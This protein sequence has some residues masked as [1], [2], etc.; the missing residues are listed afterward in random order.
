MPET[1][2]PY[3]S[4]LHDNAKFFF[5]GEDHDR[6]PNV[7]ISRKLFLNQTGAVEELTRFDAQCKVETAL[8]EP[9]A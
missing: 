5:L 9:A 8:K 2:Q 6:P 7:K 3:L 1:F 4:N